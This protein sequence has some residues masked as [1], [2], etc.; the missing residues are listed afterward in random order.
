ML[1]QVPA[2]FAHVW[3]TPLQA[4]LQQCPSAQL[5]LAHCVPSVQV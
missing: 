1:M 2:L 3:Q 4:V 5:P